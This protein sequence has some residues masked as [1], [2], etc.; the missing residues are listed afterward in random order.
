MAASPEE[1]LDIKEFIPSYFKSLTTSTSTLLGQFLVNESNDMQ[2]YDLEHCVCLKDKYNNT[3]N[4]LDYIRFS[5]SNECLGCHRDVFSYII[6]IFKSASSIEKL[7]QDYLQYIFRLPAIR[8]E[9]IVL[10]D[11]VHDCS[12]A[13]SKFN[14]KND[15]ELDNANAIRLFKSRTNG[16]PSLTIALLLLRKYI[17]IFKNAGARKAFV[18]EIKSL[19]INSD[20]NYCFKHERRF[21]RQKRILGTTKTKDVTKFVILYPSVGPKYLSLEVD[22]NIDFLPKLINSHFFIMQNEQ[23]LINTLDRTIFTSDIILQ[24]LQYQEVIGNADILYC[25]FECDHEIYNNFQYACVLRKESVNVLDPRSKK[26]N[27]R[28]TLTSA[29]IKKLSNFIIVDNRRLK[30]L[31]KDCK[32]FPKIT[33]LVGAQNR[34]ESCGKEFLKLLQMPEITR[35]LL[36]KRMEVGSNSIIEE[37][38]YMK[39]IITLAPDQEKAFC[40]AVRKV[41]LLEKKFKLLDLGKARFA[42]STR[43]KQFMAHRAFLSLK[44]ANENIH[45]VSNEKIESFVVSMQ[46]IIREILEN[47]E[48]DI[49]KLD[50]TQQKQWLKEASKNPEI[51]AFQENPD[52]NTLDATNLQNIKDSPTAGAILL[53]RKRVLNCVIIYIMLCTGC[54]FRDINSK[55]SYHFPVIEQECEYFDDCVMTIGMSKRSESLTKILKA[56]TSVASNAKEDDEYLSR[57]IKQVKQIRNVLL[58]LDSRVDIEENNGEYALNANFSFKK[59]DYNKLRNNPSLHQDFL[60]L[61]RLYGNIQDNIMNRLGDAGWEDSKAVFKTAFIRSKPLLFS[62]TSK[63]LLQITSYLYALKVDME[64]NQISTLAA[65]IMLDF[66]YIP[67]DKIHDTALHRKVLFLSSFMDNN[68]YSQ[69]LTP[70]AFRKLY[71]SESYDRF[72]SMRMTK[73]AWIAQVLGHDTNNYSTSLTYQTVQISRQQITDNSRLQRLLDFMQNKFQDT[74][75]K[76]QE[77]MLTLARRLQDNKQLFMAEKS[78]SQANQV[79]QLSQGHSA[80]HNVRSAGIKKGEIEDVSLGMSQEKFEDQLVA[81]LLFYKTNIHDINSSLLLRRNLL[82]TEPVLASN[83]AITLIL[84]AILS[85]IF[86]TSPCCSKHV[87]KFATQA[88]FSKKDMATFRKHIQHE[89]LIHVTPKIVRDALEHVENIL[90][91]LGARNLEVYVETDL[92]LCVLIVALYYCRGRANN[93]KLNEIDENRIESFFKTS[94][95]VKIDL[96]QL[97]LSLNSNTTIHTDEEFSIIGIHKTMSIS[98]LQSN[99]KVICLNQSNIQGSIERKLSLV[100]RY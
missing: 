99:L 55:F 79:N 73:N 85:T 82:R 94:C 75:Q 49:S 63:L 62:M 1:F 88:D 72:G 17:R 67:V 98:L 84:V 50:A 20:F 86:F 37:I 14:S 66:D 90:Q 7:L 33:E 9:L 77:F 48:W 34:I 54:R 60:K 25:L 89:H 92:P 8:D 97:V 52:F 47:P 21:R 87:L 74:I 46:Y 58:L 100:M 26:L 96:E 35:A 40:G 18:Q 27:T 64:K 61:L 95:S 56:G 22:T 31:H 68:P 69:N 29:S 10:S 2:T 12:N 93:S 70:H 30:D 5:F 38:N 44:A 39:S 42:P 4:C 23:I 81:A 65:N 36:L 19:E 83:R 16:S 43:K 28:K 45:F 59:F 32:M 3:Y 15:E 51:W 78:D 80:I 41:L 6:N 57:Q 53:T 71:A 24:P 13:N 11:P 76:K 91:G